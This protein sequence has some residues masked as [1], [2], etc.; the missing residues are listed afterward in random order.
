ML[1]YDNEEKMY[2][3]KTVILLLIKDKARN[4]HYCLVKNLS[5]LLSSQVSK[6][7]GKRYFCYYC[8]NGFKTETFLMNHKEYCSKY[9]C[10]KTEYPNKEK[11]KEK[12]IKFNHHERMHKVPFGIYADF[13]CFTKPLNNEVSNDPNKSYTNHYQKHE[14]SGFC[15]Y[16]KCFDDSLYDQDPVH[17]SKKSDDDNIAQMFL[18]SLEGTEKNL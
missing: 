15:Y 13:E 8:L 11:E 14:P 6:H 4:T 1:G 16:V 9:D 5:R 2:I 12:I 18:N 7:K 17:Y 3:L 10:V